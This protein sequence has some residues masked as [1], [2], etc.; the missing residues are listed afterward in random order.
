M[1][2]GW[3]KLYRISLEKSIWQNIKLWRMATY[4]LLKASHQEHQE[5][6]G[7]TPIKLQPGQFV[8]GRKKAAKET[9]L[10]EQT[11]RTL[12]QNLEKKLGFLTIKS[13]KQFSIITICNWE[14]YQSNDSSNN[15]GINQQLTN[16]QPTTNQQLTTNKNDKKGKNEKNNPPRDEH[17][18]AFKSA[19]EEFHPGQSYA[20]Q[21]ADFVQL[22]KL[23]VHKGDKFPTPAQL[24]TVAKWHWGR[25]QYT[26]KTSL[27]IRGLCTD[28]SSLAVQYNNRN[29]PSP[30]YAQPQEVAI[31]E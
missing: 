29:T 21:Q 7:L 14:R 25:G 17:A 22:Q 20:W 2:E 11:V 27:T 1:A 28:W 8:F 13:T 26:P 19:F 23:R 3:V 18:D 15:Q 4:C 24:V 5:M 9:K 10:S 6:V 12:I 30:Q 16:N 31:R